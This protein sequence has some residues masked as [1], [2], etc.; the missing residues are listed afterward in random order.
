M[1]TTDLPGSLCRRCG[2]AL[3]AASGSGDAVPTPGDVSVC[4]YCGT[5]AVFTDELRL[6][7]TTVDETKGFLGDARLMRALEMIWEDSV[8]QDDDGALYACG[9]RVTWGGDLFTIEACH[10]PCAVAQW[11]LGVAEKTGK[12]I[13][14]I[15]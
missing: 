12:S 2:K 10:E 1:K 4:M 6:R 7:E 8:V 3:D 14:W 11:V 5:L 15:R 13:G 9:C